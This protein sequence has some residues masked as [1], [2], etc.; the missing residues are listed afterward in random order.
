MGLSQYSWWLRIFISAFFGGIL[1]ASVL[2]ACSVPR[3]VASPT[4]VVAQ[5]EVVPA[6]ED[7]MVLGN[8]TGKLLRIVDHKGDVACWLAQ[9]TVDGGIGNKSQVSTTVTISCLPLQQ[10]RGNYNR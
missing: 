6:I 7:L 3:Q 1:A 9:S 8:G 2:I 5:E 10:L 4:S